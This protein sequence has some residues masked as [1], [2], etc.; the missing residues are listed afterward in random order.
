LK[1]PTHTQYLGPSSLPSW[2]SL[3]FFAVT[4]GHFCGIGKW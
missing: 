3:R 4:L 1:V 2:V